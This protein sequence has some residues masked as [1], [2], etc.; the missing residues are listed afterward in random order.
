MNITCFHIEPWQ[1]IILKEKLAKHN[2]KVFSESLRPDNLKEAKDAEILITRARFLHLDLHK[3]TLDKLPNLKLI[4]T[5]STG[6]DH[7]DIDACKEKD[8]TVANVPD[9]GANTV[10]EQTL[11]LMLAASRKIPQSVQSTK[12]GSFDNT[13]LE[14]IDLK[15]KT[16][17][18][19]G[20]GNIGLEVIK[21]AKAFEMN[22]ISYDVVHNNE[23]AQ[24]LG[25]TY[26]ELDE[27]LKQADIITLHAPY[28]QH[29][30]HLL[31]H[32]NMTN[33]KK[34]SIIINTARGALIETNALIFL[35]ENKTIAAA[36]LD[37]IEGEID[38]L[39]LERQPIPLKKLIKMDNVLITPHNA[40]NTR[41][42]KTRMLETTIENIEAYLQ[43]KAKNVIS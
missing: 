37:V 14:G 17:G 32:E 30:H 27:L 18:V 15:N 42:A 11:A 8:I 9:Y 13:D 38:E 21:R 24:Q 1:E 35:L 3:E 34:G 33:I 26:V 6:F 5:M 36:A 4:A 43:G 7:I 2:L 19:I 29:T 23:A 31:N 20:S 40:S 22:V 25:F 12:A 39:S 16:L 10:A 41:E 28:N